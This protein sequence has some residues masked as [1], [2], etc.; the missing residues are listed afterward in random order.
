[1]SQYSHQRN[2]LQPNL[3]RK[4]MKSLTWPTLVTSALLANVN[5]NAFAHIVLHRRTSY[6][7]YKPQKYRY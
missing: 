2:R 6:E 1:M 3:R 7:Y 4:Q 5:G